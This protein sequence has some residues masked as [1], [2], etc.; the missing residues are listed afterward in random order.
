[1]DTERKS[2]DM[3]KPIP[4]WMCLAIGI[5]FILTLVMLLAG[6]RLLGGQ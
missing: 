6:V 1:M 2:A 5:G 4:G 3:A